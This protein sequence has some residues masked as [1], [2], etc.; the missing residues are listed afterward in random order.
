MISHDCRVN[1][2]T[3]TENTFDIFFKKGYNTIK[4]SLIAS[5]LL[6]KGV[7]KTVGHNKIKTGPAFITICNYLG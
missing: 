5:P 1:V 2:T 4:E 3:E 6:N 7:I